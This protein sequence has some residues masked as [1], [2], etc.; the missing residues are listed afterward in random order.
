[1]ANHRQFRTSIIVFRRI[2]HFR[3]CLFALVQA[4]Q[5][6]DCTLNSQ[7]KLLG[8]VWLDILQNLQ[9]VFCTH[10]S[11]QC[12]LHVRSLFDAVHNRIGDVLVFSKSLSQ[13]SIRA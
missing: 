7:A 8:F 12:V 11:S 6:Y 3:D 13:N 10:Q 9:N 1:M 4:I 2:T 5:L